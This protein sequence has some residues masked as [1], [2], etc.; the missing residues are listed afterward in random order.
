[1][2]MYVARYAYN[3]KLEPQAGYL[4]LEVGDAVRV[5]YG[6]SSLG[7]ARNLHRYYIYGNVVATGSP[8]EGWFPTDALQAQAPDVIWD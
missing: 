5:T 2:G 6:L 7:D 4:T 8:R 1:M 3:G